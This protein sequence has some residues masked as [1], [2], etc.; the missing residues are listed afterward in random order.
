MSRKLLVI[1]VAVLALCLSQFSAGWSQ[2]KPAGMKATH[3]KVAKAAS[4]KGAP[5]NMVA[6]CGC[7]KVFVPDASTKYIT[8]EGK[9]YACCSDPCHEKMSVS[10]AAAA[11]MV[12]DNLAKVLAEYSK[13]AA[14]TTDSPKQ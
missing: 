12:D 13:P 4:H 6:V 11:K 14:T 1:A 10:P 2:D 9:E 7:G 5:A 8:Y 3:A